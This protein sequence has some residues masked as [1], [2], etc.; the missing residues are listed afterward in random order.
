MADLSFKLSRAVASGRADK[1]VP[2]NRS[3]ILLALLR[4]RAE[5]HRQGL[6]GQEQR[7]RDQIRWALPLHDV[8]PRE[9][10]ADAA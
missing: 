7:L 5:A 1:G 2:K 9:E 4:K 8:E 6:S 3:E 10:P